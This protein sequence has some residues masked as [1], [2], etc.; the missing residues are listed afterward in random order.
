MASFDFKKASAILCRSGWLSRMPEAF[1]VEVL[2]HA[3]L[4]EFARSKVIYRAGDPMGGIYG[5]VA[6][7]VAVNTSPPDAA[8]QLIH[9]GAPGFWTGEGSFLARQ[10]RR[11]ELR[12]I[13]AAT[14][15]H[16]PLHAMDRMEANDSNA[17]RCFA[18]IM[19]ANVDVLIRIVHDLQHPDTGR[20]I[21]AVLTRACCA[22]DGK[23]LLTQSELGAMANASRK[24][25]NAALH[26][27]AEAGW[28]SSTYRAIAVTDADGLRRFAAGEPD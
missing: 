2:R 7:I 9:I 28:A 11:I 20:R 6:G 21:A 25:V 26:R 12:A 8:P 23:V 18:Q 16:L 3:K 1:R 13:S 17:V 15:M 10:P 14:L 24:Q 4:F 5:L 19:M 22:S 27:F